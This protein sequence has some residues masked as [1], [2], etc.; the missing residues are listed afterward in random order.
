VISKRKYKTSLADRVVFLLR[1]SCVYGQ[2]FL[3]NPTCVYQKKKRVYNCKWHKLQ[4]C[5]SPI[6]KVSTK[7]KIRDQD[8]LHFLSFATVEWIDVLTPLRVTF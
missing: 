3:T 6:T 4:T 2:V 5:A 1:K 7:Y 8:K